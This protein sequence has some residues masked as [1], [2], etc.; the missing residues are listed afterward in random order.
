MARLQANAALFLKLARAAGFDT[1][2]ASPHA[3]IPVILGSSITA[4]RYA[5]KLF[6]RGINV[7]PI[8]YPAVAEK[9]AR[10]RFLLSS[11]H[12]H[13][14]LRATVAALTAIREDAKR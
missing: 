1:G 7:Q 6:E 5:Q 14:D 12:S 8:I 3:I 4:A 13:E 9:A 11:E 10:L 2:V